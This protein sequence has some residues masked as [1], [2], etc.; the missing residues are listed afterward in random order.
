MIRKL[1][2]IQVRTII[3]LHTYGKFPRY[4]GMSYQHLSRRYDMY[5][6]T[7]IVSVNKYQAEGLGAFSMRA[8]KPFIVRACRGRTMR[9]AYDLCM[10]YEG[11]PQQYTF[12]QFSNFVVKYAIPYKHRRF[13]AKDGKERVFHVDGDDYTNLEYKAKYFVYARP[14]NTMRCKH[15]C[16]WTDALR[17]VLQSR[18]LGVTCNG[19]R[20]P[21]EWV[22]KVSGAE[23]LFIR[24][25]A[26]DYGDVKDLIP[27]QENYPYV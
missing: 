2:R 12:L 16:S 10:S 23:R 9:E 4:K 24:E 8:L 17:L 18:Y 25:I 22:M 1:S 3:R 11:A 19:K 20:V 26:K 21:I 6:G 15:K 5:A 7:L 27:N 13:Y 14:V